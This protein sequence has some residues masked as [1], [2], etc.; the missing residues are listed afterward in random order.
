MFPEVITTNYIISQII[1]FVVSIII[2]WGFFLKR[3]KLFVSQIASNMILATSYLFLNSLVGA[4]GTFL[5]GC[6]CIL[7]YYFARKGKDI[8]VWAV[9]ISCL[10]FIWSTTAF[11]KNFYDLFQR[12][13]YLFYTFSF[14]SKDERIMRICLLLA[15]MSGIIFNLVLF[16]Y[17]KVIISIVE[18][19]SILSA[20]IMFYK[21]RIYDFKILY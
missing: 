18:F 19:F 8:P 2:C 10:F 15:T 20:L 16:N 14:I 6:R 3:E 17:V 13:V 1:G 9:C 21:K 7:F 12:G 4:V 11:F 5:A